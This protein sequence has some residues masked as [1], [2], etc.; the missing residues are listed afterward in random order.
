MV[1]LSPRKE[2]TLRPEDI[3]SSIEEHGDSIALYAS[4]C[5]VLHWTGI[6]YAIYNC[7][8]VLVLLL[9]LT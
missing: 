8:S 7:R 9:A 1:L 4:R 2:E 5:T 3:I 6:R